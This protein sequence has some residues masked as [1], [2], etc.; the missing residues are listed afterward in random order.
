MPI[1]QYASDK[2]VVSYS[3]WNA[4]MK[5]VAGFQLINRFTNDIMICLL[6]M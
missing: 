3:Q 4:L 1:E 5:L 6:Y 2:I